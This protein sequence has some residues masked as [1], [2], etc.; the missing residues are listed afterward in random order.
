MRKTLFFKQDARD[1]L[2]RGM[3]QLHDAV[4]S[5]L[6]P[7]G[8]RVVISR[9]GLV[10][11][12]TKDGVTVAKSIRLV[13]A[14][15][16]SGA[17]LLREA[18]ERAAEKVG[19]G[20]TSSCI[21]SY[22]LVEE[23]TTLMK[24]EDINPTHLL[25]GLNK[26]TDM[27]KARLEEMSTQINDDLSKVIAIATISTNNDAELGKIIGEA[28][29]EVGVDGALMTDISPSYDSYFERTPGLQI[30]QGMFSPI[31]ITDP[32][33]GVAYREGPVRILLSDYKI[34][35]IHFIHQAVEI[36]NAEGAYLMIIA[37]AVDPMVMR[38]MA[39][40][41]RA[42]AFQGVMVV[43]P[44][45]GD[46]RREELMDIAVA[47]GGQV[48]SEYTGVTWSRFD[49]KAMMG[50]AT[51]YS[52][53]KKDTIISGGGGEANLID[54]RVKQIKAQIKRT[55]NEYEQRMLK[56]RIARFIGGIA[57]IYIGGYSD[58][59]LAEKKDRID[60]ALFATKAAMKEGYVPGGGVTYHMLRDAID[61]SKAVNADEKAGMQLLSGALSAPLKYILR[62][63]GVDPVDVLKDIRIDNGYNA[64]T[65]KFEDLMQSGVIDPT[66]VVRVVIETAVSTASMI[67]ST[68]CLV[69]IYDDDMIFFERNPVSY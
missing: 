32:D 11:H 46:R 1:V 29:M 59:E 44:Q 16:E 47:T 4:A 65:D 53:S 63:G 18:A 43:A 6:G 57:V 64:L 66:L 38:M 50:Y 9:I 69:S 35:D 56:Q 19:D 10:P 39:Q 54:E 25:R 23:A 40:N 45:S 13:D 62:N 61:Y 7:K 20:T 68:D 8:K 3:Q 51:G 42:G 22:A 24:T 41:V 30:D 5:T 67:I 52:V 27:V 49:P 17:A 37:P 60:D 21:L 36:A 31:F 28:A 15:E 33:Q 26:A 12:V 48:I 14:A 2:M 55:H 34:T 58:I